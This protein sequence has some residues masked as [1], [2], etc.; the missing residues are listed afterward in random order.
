MDPPRRTGRPS[1]SAVRG[2]DGVITGIAVED[3]ITGKLS[4]VNPAVPFPG[5]PDLVESIVVKHNGSVAW[6]AEV[7][8][9]PQL[10]QVQADDIEGFRSMAEGPEIDGDSLL[11]QG[12]KLIWNDTGVPQSAM[13]R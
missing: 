11:L 2:I 8:T 10:F 1:W 6:A 3:L 7:D 5:G 12:S 13:L 9:Y 4:H